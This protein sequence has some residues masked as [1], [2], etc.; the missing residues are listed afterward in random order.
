MVELNLTSEC[1]YFFFFFFEIRHLSL[2]SERS[3]WIGPHI[4]K[5][6]EAKWRCTLCKKLFKAS[7]F[8][9]KHI[10]NKH[11]DDFKSQ[12]EEVCVQAKLTALPVTDRRL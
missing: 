9:E 1:A 11:S 5:E 8:V 7:E 6:D 3:R 4:G 10:V 2:I 12:M